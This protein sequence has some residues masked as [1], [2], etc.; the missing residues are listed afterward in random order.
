MSLP[1]PVD[2]TQPRRRTP[3][4]VIRN[5]ARHRATALLLEEYQTRFQ[6]LLTQE[7]RVATNEAAMLLAMGDGAVDNVVLL[8]PGMRL[9][10]QTPGERIDVARCKRCH[11]N[12]DAGHV[13]PRCGA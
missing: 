11:T 5:R 4:R 10:G 8:R 13:C 1:Q 12:H 9:E 7:Q 6:V 3:A 2:T